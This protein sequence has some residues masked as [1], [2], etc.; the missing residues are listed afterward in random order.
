[1]TPVATPSWPDVLPAGNPAVT[2][3]WSCC[4]RPRQRKAQV[5]G[6]PV[7]NDRAG[8]VPGGWSARTV[9]VLLDKSCPAWC[10]G[11]HRVDD[12]D[13]AF[14]DRIV[15]E[16]DDVSVELSCIEYHDPAETGSTVIILN[17]DAAA[18]PIELGEDDAIRMVGRL[19]AEAGGTSWLTAGLRS[20]LDLL[21]PGAGWIRAAF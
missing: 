21:D 1:M 3:G 8:W 19:E 4:S 7:S 14:H 12:R 18:G 6:G 17:M 2:L 20:A 15:A 16:S 13:A 10:D 11:Q 9:P 5:A